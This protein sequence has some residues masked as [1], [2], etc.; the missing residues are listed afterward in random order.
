MANYILTPASPTGGIF[1]HSGGILE[2]IVAEESILRSS[3]RVVIKYESTSGVYKTI[4]TEKQEDV[5]DT[6]KT[7]LLQLSAG[8]YRAELVGGD[9]ITSADVRLVSVV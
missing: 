1:A 6:P 3:A 4:P 2:V 5:I 9:S 8:N 7:V